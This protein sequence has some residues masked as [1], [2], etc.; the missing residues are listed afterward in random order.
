[1]PP[2]MG[3]PAASPSMGGMGGMDGPSVPPVLGLYAGTEILFLHTEASDQGVAEML[4]AMMGSP[5]LAVGATAPRPDLQ[6]AGRPSVIGS[7]RGRS[8]RHLHAVLCDAQRVPARSPWRF[9]RR[10]SRS[11]PQA[12]LHAPPLT[13]YPP[14]AASIA[15]AT[16]RCRRSSTC[17]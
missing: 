15:R 1:M 16:S 7:S 3:A 11:L 5:V 10:P 14:S 13:C 2:G 17:P 4:T 9:D 6:R 12:E 8:Q